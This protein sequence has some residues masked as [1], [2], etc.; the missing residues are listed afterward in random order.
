MT[1]H[2]TLCSEDRLRELL[3]KE[4]QLTAVRAECEELQRENK[5][6]LRECIRAAG[7]GI[8]TA[9]SLIPVCWVFRPIVDRYRRMI[10]RTLRQAR[11]EG[12]LS[13][14]KHLQEVEHVHDAIFAEESTL[15]KWRKAQGGRA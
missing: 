9:H 14:L 15:S 10:I 11:E 8:K 7:E 1:D 3:E 5:R 4:Q 2:L 6:L 13:M 12:A